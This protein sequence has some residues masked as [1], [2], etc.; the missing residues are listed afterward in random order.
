MEKNKQKSKT[1]FYDLLEVPKDASQEQI[2][3]QYKK[4]ALVSPSLLN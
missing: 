4:L 2:K 1:Y 3:T